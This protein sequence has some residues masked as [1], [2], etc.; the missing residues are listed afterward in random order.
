[1]AASHLLKVF[2]GPVF[3]GRPVPI[4]PNIYSSAG[5]PQNATEVPTTPVPLSASAIQTSWCGQSAAFAPD[6]AGW[7]D[8]N[9]FFSANL[10][11]SFTPEGSGP[12]GSSP[13]FSMPAS[14]LQNRVNRP[15]PPTP[16][17][18]DGELVSLRFPDVLPHGS[19]VSQGS[20]SPLRT[21]IPYGV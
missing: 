4:P 1:M 8:A 10:P 16:V 17:Q 3:V 12:Q 9:T 19:S 21:R 20:R 18:G 2:E 13:L 6:T 14:T 5:M 15:V 11:A 7:N